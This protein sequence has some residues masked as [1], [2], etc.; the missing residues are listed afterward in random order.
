MSLILAGSIS[1]DSAFKEHLFLTEVVIKIKS[2]AWIRFP[3]S[4]SMRIRIQ[5]RLFIFDT[6]PNPTSHLMRIRILLLWHEAKIFILVKIICEIYE[7]Y[8]ALSFNYKKAKF[9]SNM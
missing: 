6:N 4:T 7:N 8:Q 5:I 2:I 3:L 1:L 9:V